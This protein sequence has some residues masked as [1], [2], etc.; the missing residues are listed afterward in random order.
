M[1]R[2]SCH[3]LIETVKRL[4][5]E[6]HEVGAMRRQSHE[7]ALWFVT[8]ASVLCAVLSFSA[9]AAS[10][11]RANAVEQELSTTRARLDAKTQTLGECESFAQHSVDAQRQYAVEIARL[12]ER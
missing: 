4:Q 8:A 1:Y 2:D 11:A 5:R 10:H 6:A 9:L 7:H 3:S 12:R